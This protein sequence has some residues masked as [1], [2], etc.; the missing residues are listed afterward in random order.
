MVKKIDNLYQ[1]SE[2]AHACGVSR[3]TL[4]RMEEKGLLKPTYVSKE[5]GRRYY[6]N[7]SIARVLQVEKFKKMGLSDEVIIEYFQSGGQVGGMLG[8]L[9]ERLSEI[10]RSVEEMRLFASVNDAFSVSEIVLPEVV[11]RM[12]KTEGL[13][14]ADKYNTM[15]E[16]YRECVKDGCV[17]SSEPLF[18]AYDRKDFIDGYI[19]TENYPF[20][21]CVPLK[22][23]T[24]DAVTLPAC[25][26]L[27]VLYYGDYASS[28]RAWL[29]LGQELRERNLKP[30]GFSRSIGIVAPYTGKEISV[31]R[32][33]SRLVIPVE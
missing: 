24:K 21:V 1:I 13:T 19:G 27:S 14:I 20:Y 2:A 25:K 4:L 8:A 26:A 18:S 16:F 29:R 28:D 15:F 22:K 32:Y 7:F 30:A 33:C 12:K 9:E 31:K 5:S 11:C 17:F 23:K 6:D 3:S 10:Q